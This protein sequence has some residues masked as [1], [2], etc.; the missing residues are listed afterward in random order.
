[1]NLTIIGIPSFSDAVVPQVNIAL[2]APKR[3]RRQKTSFSWAAPKK[4]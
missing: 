4:F 3:L 1:M 2:P